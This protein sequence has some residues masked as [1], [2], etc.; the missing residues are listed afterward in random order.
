MKTLVWMLLVACAAESA[1][2]QCCR[3]VP[4]TRPG[5]A[6]ACWNDCDKPRIATYQ[7]SNALR[8][9][10]DDSP[11]IQ[12]HSK[13]EWVPA[14]GQWLSAIPL[15]DRPAAAAASEPLASSATFGSMWEV[16]F[17]LGWKCQ[18]GR[19]GWDVGLRVAHQ[20]QSAPEAEAEIRCM[21][22]REYRAQNKEICQ[23]TLTARKR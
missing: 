20:A 3:N 10:E 22:E 4:S 8:T 11:V 5:V 17:S 9:W 21:L 13:V 18:D 23:L 6:I 12:P 7:L 2:A 19:C 16:S 1:C 15:G 14:G